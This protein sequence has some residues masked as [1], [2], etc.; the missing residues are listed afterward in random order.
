MKTAAMCVLEAATWASA[1]VTIARA[2]GEDD[3][4]A[5]VARQGRVSRNAVWSLVYRKPK[6][7]AAET[8]LALGGLYENA[9]ER[10]AERYAAEREA[11]QAKTRIGRALVG[12]ADR[13]AGAEIQDV[14]ESDEL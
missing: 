5:A 4:F 8:Y 14:G 7:V 2:R 10:Q 1:L 12:W 11:T 3:P 6:R 9:C 13:L